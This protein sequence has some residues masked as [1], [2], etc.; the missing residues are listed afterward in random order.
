[1]PKEALYLHRKWKE[2]ERDMRSEKHE[3]NTNLFLVK[4]KKNRRRAV[5]MLE[6]R[7]ERTLFLC[8]HSNDQSRS[9]HRNTF[10]HTFNGKHAD[11]F[12]TV[13]DGRR[14]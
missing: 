9:W 2:R 3:E 10:T 8:S 13:M 11:S 4:R 6:K 12:N 14:K 5:S 7:R 1:M